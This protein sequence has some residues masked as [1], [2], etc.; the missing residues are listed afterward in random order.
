MKTRAE[1]L[2]NAVKEALQM[3]ARGRPADAMETLSAALDAPTSGICPGCVK[4]CVNEQQACPDDALQSAPAQVVSKVSVELVMRWLWENV[5][6]S[7]GDT[8]REAAL[9]LGVDFDAAPAKDETCECGASRSDHDTQ[10]RRWNKPGCDDAV[11][12]CAGFQAAREGSR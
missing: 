10:G 11:M 8:V 2:E 5:L 1:D 9:R 4:C 12:M 6:G 7:D 3:L